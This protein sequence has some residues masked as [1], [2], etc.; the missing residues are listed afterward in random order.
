MLSSSGDMISST[1]STSSGIIPQLFFQ[2]QGVFSFYF[3][4]TWM[5]E[6]LIAKRMIASVLYINTVPS[7]SNATVN[8]TISAGGTNISTIFDSSLGVVSIVDLPPNQ[9]TSLTIYILATAPTLFCM[10]SFIIT[11][12]ENS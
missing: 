11:I 2:F 8:L 12:P 10:E 5:S 9:I 4:R 7:I 6:L 1:G 3:L